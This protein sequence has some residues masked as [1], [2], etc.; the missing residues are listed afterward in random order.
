MTAP[1]D[2]E[3]DRTI[4][5]LVTPR[6]SKVARIVADTLQALGRQSRSSRLWGPLGDEAPDPALDAVLARVEAL[7]QAGT[8][9]VAGDASRPRDSEVR[10][11]G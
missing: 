11:P 1:G 10:T 7:A 4:L 6:W 5:S 2:A 8:L 9:D 3:I